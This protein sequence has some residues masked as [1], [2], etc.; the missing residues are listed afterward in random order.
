[1]CKSIYLGKLNLGNSMIDL[2]HPFYNLTW[3][4]FFNKLKSKNKQEDRKIKKAISLFDS[5]Y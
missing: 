1:M 4:F 2:I 5:I 3:T